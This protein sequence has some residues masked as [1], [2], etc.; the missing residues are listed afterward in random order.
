[1]GMVLIKG[2]KYIVMR[3]Q[4]KPCDQRWGCPSNKEDWQCLSLRLRSVDQRD[5]RGW[6]SS[7]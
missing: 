6:V 5:G 7:S 3:S 1:M 2:E 4:D